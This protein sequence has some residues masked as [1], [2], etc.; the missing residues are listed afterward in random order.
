MKEMTVLP[1]H[2]YVSAT[3][4]KSPCKLYIFTM[5]KGI[6]LGHW[7]DSDFF[8]CM[9]PIEVPLKWKGPFSCLVTPFEVA[10]Q[11]ISPF[12]IQPDSS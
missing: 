2:S 9:S 5:E 3:I 10:F 6:F 4:K 7:K 11:V 1:Y 8:L 12:P